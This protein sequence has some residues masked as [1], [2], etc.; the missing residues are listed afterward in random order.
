MKTACS[1]KSQARKLMTISNSGIHPLLILA[2]MTYHDLAFEAI[3]TFE[4]N[5]IAP[6]D[7]CVLSD[8]CAVLFTNESFGKTHLES[9]YDS[10]MVILESEPEP[11]GGQGVGDPL[12]RAVESL[13]KVG[14][15]SA[16]RPMAS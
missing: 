1:K 16:A 15:L 8:D 10:G 9:A 4:I 6:G 3:E 12:A 11:F 5:K 14:K 13:K 7:F 2:K